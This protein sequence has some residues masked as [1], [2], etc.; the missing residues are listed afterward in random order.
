MNVKK[1]LRVAIVSA[2]QDAKGNV[3]AVKAYATLENSVLIS[4]F[5]KATSRYCVHKTISFLFIIILFYHR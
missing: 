5:Y 4:M 3:C 1:F 2:T